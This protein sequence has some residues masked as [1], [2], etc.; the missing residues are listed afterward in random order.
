LAAERAQLEERGARVDES[1]DALADRQLAA[2]LVALDRAVVATGARAATVVLAA[3]SSSTRAAIASWLQRVSAARGRAGC[4]GRACRMIG[5]RVCAARPTCVRGLIRP[6][7][8]AVRVT[9][10][11]DSDRPGRA[12][13]CV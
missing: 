4:A 8:P 12:F 11:T 6:A 5:S 13:M 2:L 7:A 9:T 1:V 3:G 10:I